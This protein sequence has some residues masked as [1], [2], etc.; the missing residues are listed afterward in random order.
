MGNR[1][2][3]RIDVFLHDGNDGIEFHKNMTELVHHELTGTVAIL[4][5][6]AT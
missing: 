6:F 3:K 4:G 2:L 5:T 1:N